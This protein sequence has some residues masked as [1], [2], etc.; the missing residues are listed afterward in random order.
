MFTAEKLKPSV[1]EQMFLVDLEQEITLE[2]E[3]LFLLGGLCAM[4]VKKHNYYYCWVLVGL[5]FSDVHVIKT[6]GRVLAFFFSQKGP[7]FLVL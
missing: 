3:S 5:F 2:D 6:I 7:F 4:V 1:S